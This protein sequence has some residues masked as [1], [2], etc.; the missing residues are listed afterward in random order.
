MTHQPINLQS[1]RT[2]IPKLKAYR[3]SK[4]PTVAGLTCH[5]GCDIIELDR[6]L[7]RD[8]EVGQ[9]ARQTFNHIVKFW[10]EKALTSNCAIA[11]LRNLARFGWEQW[12]SK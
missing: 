11:Y 2:L 12:L 4:T 7:G 10:S 6:L 5:L 3:A 8:D 1:P 9:E